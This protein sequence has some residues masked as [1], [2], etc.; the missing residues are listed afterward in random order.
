[1]MIAPSSSGNW[2]AMDQ[3]VPNFEQVSANPQVFDYY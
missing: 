3:R 2:A 1:M